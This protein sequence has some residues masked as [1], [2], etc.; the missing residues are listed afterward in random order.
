MATVARIIMTSKYVT[1]VARIITKSIITTSKYV[2][3][4]ARII[5]TS[6][7]IIIMKK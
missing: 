2:T 1:T 7:W 5:T 6:M 3:T 4:V